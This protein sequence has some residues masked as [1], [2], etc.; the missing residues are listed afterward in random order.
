[1][2][3]MRDL[4]SKKTTSLKGWL[5]WIDYCYRNNDY[6]FASTN[7]AR[8]L[9]R[10]CFDFDLESFAD[11]GNDCLIK[12]YTQE[13]VFDIDFGT[14]ELNLP[15]YGGLLA[16]VVNHHLQGYRL[17]ASTNEIEA[18]RLEY[19]NDGKYGLLLENPFVDIVSQRSYFDQEMDYLTKHRDVIYDPDDSQ[20]A[21]LLNNGDNDPE[22]VI[23]YSEY[24][25]G[26][27][28]LLNDDLLIH[29]SLVHD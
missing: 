17:V 26:Y 6:S 14:K 10:V 1:M 4:L 16:L 19:V 22:E 25:C 2:F 8:P 27:N 12:L 13:E 9:S 20:F 29:V 15:Y 5:D 18:L 7:P 23:G 3:T 21:N 11:L 24:D 28:A